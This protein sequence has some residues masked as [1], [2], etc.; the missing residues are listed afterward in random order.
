MMTNR[1]NDD[2]DS[3]ENGPSAGPGLI[4]GE[5]LSMTFGTVVGSRNGQRGLDGDH[6][7]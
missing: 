4:F 1:L 7:G 6:L 2:D 3:N 5:S